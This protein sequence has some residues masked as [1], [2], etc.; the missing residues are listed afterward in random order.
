MRMWNYGKKKEKHV[1][2]TIF[3]ASPP[4]MR[5]N[6][7]QLNPADYLSGR[8]I[9]DVFTAG[10]F[11][12]FAQMLFIMALYPFFFSKCTALNRKHCL[13]G[14]LGVA[15]VLALLGIAAAG[16]IS[17]DVKGDSTGEM[18]AEASNPADST[19]AD[20]G[21]DIPGTDVSAVPNEKEAA[22]SSPVVVAH[23]GYSSLFPENTLASFAG[24]VDIGADMIELDVQ[25]S[26][27]GA[28]MV[29]HDGDLSKLGLGGSV[30]DYSCE[31]LRAMDVGSAFGGEYAGERM[32]TLPEPDTTTVA[33]S[34]L[35][36]CSFSRQSVK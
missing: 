1:L 10:L 22:S 36:P 26:K 28:L 31:E 32:P 8:H 17:E 35:L 20:V 14:I 3:T 34:K 13:T 15:A 11:M 12:M 29:Y 30:A 2:P 16:K 19:I 33:P 27:D 6:F 21:D 25:L 24:A 4:S 5:R 7:R 23:R 9:S 18:T